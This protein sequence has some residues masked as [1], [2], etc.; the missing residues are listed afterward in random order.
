MK[1]VL[2]ASAILAGVGV[3]SYSVRARLVE[4]RSIGSKLAEDIIRFVNFDL[5]DVDEKMLADNFRENQKEHKIPEGIL[6]SEI[7][8][9]QQADMKVY[10]LQPRQKQGDRRVLYL[11][12]GGYI[13]QPSLFHWM[14]LDGMVEDTGLEFIVPIYPKTPE[15][16]YDDAYDAVDR[17]YRELL[18]EDPEVPVLMGDS[19]G[20]GLALGFTQWLAS[21]QLPKP[22]GL[23]LISPWLDVTMTHPEMKKYAALD[24]MLKPANLK[25]I[26]RI[27]AGDA[28][29]TYYKVSPI[30]GSIDGLPKIHLF[31]GEHEVCLPDA[32][33]FAGM[34]EAAGAPYR[35]YEYPKMNH[36]FP[37][38]PIREGA[39]ARRQM[40]EILK[41]WGQVAHNV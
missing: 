30:Y 4:E 37:Q 15:F 22:Y 5:E 23:I 17:L 28:D 19:A 26:G 41:D 9:S 25:V 34:L 35:Y 38:Y 11:H 18:D 21:M 8:I 36:V 33:K 6:R 2:K 10:R 27:W 13:H 32:R 29:P 39:R 14:F 31:V 7:G 12:G 20:G 24:P 3:L 1:D 16:T 40:Q